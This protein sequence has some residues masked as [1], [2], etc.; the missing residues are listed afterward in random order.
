MAKPTELHEGLKGVVIAESTICFIDGQRGVLRYRG[1]D[2]G[3]L[4]RHSTYEETAFLLLYGELP[5]R[6]E[7]DRFSQDLKAQ[8]ALS[9]AELKILQ[10][11]PASAAPMDVLRT[12]VSAIALFD[13]Q[14][15]D[16]K[17]KPKEEEEAN[18]R[19]ALK[20]I[21]KMPTILAAHDRLRRDLKPLAP[22]EGLS[23]AANFLFMLSGKEPDETSAR[24]F[25]VCLILHA[26]HGFN[27]STF[28]ARV[29]ASTLSDLYSAITSAIG[30]LKGPLHGGANTQVIEMLQAIGS[31]QNVRPYIE[32][33]L[34]RK[35][36]VW[37]MGHRVYKTKDPR[38]IILQALIE[39]LAEVRGHHPLYDIARAV[40][41]VGTELL[42]PK[43]VYPNVDFYSAV[44]YHM[45]G[46]P[47][48]LFTPIFAM[49]RVS[50]WAAHV[51]EQYG[52]NVLIRPKEDYR[53][54]QEQ[55]YIPIEERSP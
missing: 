43:G 17:P 16:P 7:L 9:P 8:R 48:E 14:A 29:T 25:D 47:K 33:V 18:R 35:E 42:G 54:P 50:G 13:P 30:T 38:A 51:L 40:E 6:E 12:M 32:G 23:H 5:T 10:A 53:G 27:A 31:T 24:T 19:K 41:Q 45:L 26:D 15:D 52:H 11:L 37:G 36:R 44:I 28:A 39:G 55:R 21:A 22:Q 46:I 4:A 49:A 20:L 34:A 1:Y 2:I 3:D